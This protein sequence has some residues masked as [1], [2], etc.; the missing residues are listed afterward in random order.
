MT[1]QRTQQ[2]YKDYHALQQ[3]LQ[4][5]KDDY[6]LLYEKHSKLQQE[7]SE[8]TIIQSMNDMKLQYQEILRN[9]VS[10]EKYEDLLMEYERLYSTIHGVK[11]LIQNV[12]KHVHSSNTAIYSRLKIIKEILNDTIQ[13]HQDHISPIHNYE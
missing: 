3:E 13:F 2:M 8:N 1:T 5:L 9:T 7:T 12:N 11:I 6:S 10:K 4:I